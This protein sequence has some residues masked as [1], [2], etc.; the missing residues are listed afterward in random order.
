MGEALLQPVT[1]G[2]ETGNTFVHAHRVLAIEL[3]RRG[4]AIAVDERYKS[5]HVGVYIVIQWHA[6]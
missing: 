3:T 6:C 5:R 4:M 1:S 2:K